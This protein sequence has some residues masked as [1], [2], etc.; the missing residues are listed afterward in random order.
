[1]GGDSRKASIGVV[2]SGT[3]D[4]ASNGLATVN[5]KAGMDV[6]ESSNVEVRYQTFEMCLS[7]LRRLSSV[8]PSN[9]MWSLSV[10]D[11]LATWMDL[12]LLRDCLRWLVLV[13]IALVLSELGARPLWKN[14]LSSYDKQCCKLRG[15]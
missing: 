13:Q 15:L 14:Q 12:R 11:A 3:N 4:C 1:M 9:L 10:T 6:K 2:K 8:T 5:I 7:K